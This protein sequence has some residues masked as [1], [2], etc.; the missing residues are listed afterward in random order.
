MEYRL[1]DFTDWVKWVRDQQ[2][3]YWVNPK[4]LQEFLDRYGQTAP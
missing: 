2:G 1:C 4:Y 3:L